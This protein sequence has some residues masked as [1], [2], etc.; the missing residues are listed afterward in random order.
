MGA[1][2]NSKY[3]TIGGDFS[4]PPPPKM[5]AIA[6][7]IGLQ[8]SGKTTAG[9]SGAPG[10]IAFFD[11]DQ[12]GRHAA[13]KAR[14]EGKIIHYTSIEFPTKLTKLSD[15]DA[16]AAGQ[17]SWDKFV[18]NYELALAKSQTGEI[19]TIVIDTVS[20]LCEILKI[21][22]AGR[23]DK[24][25]SDYG[26]SKGIINSEIAKTIKMSRNSNANLLMLAR[27]KEEWENNQPSGRFTHVGV[28]GLAYDADWVGHIRINKGSIKRRSEPEFELQIIKAGVNIE[29]L[30]NVYTADDWDAVG[31]P[32][33]YSCLQ[34]YDGSSPED[35]T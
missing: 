10:P 5:Q 16:K 34:Q 24:K 19:R 4:A 29:E 22:V 28:D 2:K 25:N 1:N 14:E 3:S 31:G 18:R 30:W 27:A 7:M 6:M 21:A 26:A 15:V 9:L 20:E 8:G 32:F 11:I 23:S 35:W 33:V 17:K 12:R 13:Q